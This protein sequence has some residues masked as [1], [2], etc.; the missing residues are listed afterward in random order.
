VKKQEARDFPNPGRGR[1]SWEWAISVGTGSAKGA[2]GSPRRA[3]GAW[4]SPLAGPKE[5]IVREGGT[6]C[7]GTGSPGPAGGAGFPVEKRKGADSNRNDRHRG[8][9]RRPGPGFSKSRPRK[10]KLGVGDS[11]DH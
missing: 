10:G 6:A 4:G 9:G 1:E 8:H 5:Q 7:G 3:F 2:R 11:S